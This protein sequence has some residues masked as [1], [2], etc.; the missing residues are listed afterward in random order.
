M[1]NFLY[2]IEWT[3]TLS[4]VISSSLHSDIVLFLIDWRNS[5]IK[6]SFTCTSMNVFYLDVVVVLTQ[7]LIVHIW[8]ESPIINTFEKYFWVFV[9]ILFNWII[10]KNTL[11]DNVLKFYLATENTFFW[12]EFYNTILF[13][14]FILSDV[15]LHFRGVIIKSTLS[16]TCSLSFLLLPINIVTSNLS[17]LKKELKKL[18]KRLKPTD[19]HFPTKLSFFPLLS[20]LFSL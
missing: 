9:I 3:D 12:Q 15:I 20:P 2:L 7:T 5:L 1:P 8:R 4:D 11:I 6:Y 10:G 18:S 16:L 13:R 17:S 14:E 19:G